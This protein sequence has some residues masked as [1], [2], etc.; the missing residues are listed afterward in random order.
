MQ[1]VKGGDHAE[2]HVREVG[3]GEDAVAVNVKALAGEG[4]GRGMKEGIATRKG[5]AKGTGRGNKEKGEGH[6]RRGGE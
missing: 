5:D 1:R 2:H 6:K 3:V 4:A